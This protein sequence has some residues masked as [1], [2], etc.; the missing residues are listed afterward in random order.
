MPKPAPQPAMVD[1]ARLAG[2]S[3]QTVS[4]VLNDS[5]QVRPET[6]ARVRAAIDTLGYRPNR[7]ARALATQRSGLIGVLASG[8]PHLGPAATV[9]AIETATRAAG[10][11]AVVG[12]HS[13]PTPEEV[14]ESMHAFV[15]HG[16]QGIALVTP[17]RHTAETALAEAHGIPTVLIADLAGVDRPAHLVAVDQASGAG[18]AT[19][20]L[21]DGGARTIAH[22]AGPDGWFDADRRVE[23]WR[24]TLVA[25]G[26]EVPEV[27]YGDWS[28]ELGHQFG[29]EMVARG[30]PD[31]VFCA[32]DLTAIGLLAAFRTNG[33]R[34]P[35]DVTVVGFDDIPAAR[36]LS[37]P[38]STVRQ[39]FEQLGERAVAVLLE[40]IGGAA[41]SV[42]AL[43]PELVVRDTT[44]PRR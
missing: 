42:H 7:T 27:F 19:R 2:V 13:D 30:L 17:G 10:Y 31:A 4:R 39:P 18:Q 3:H 6:A 23:G 29:L 5:P 43:T 32:N 41:P 37:T 38:L 24:A 14:S 12:V 35:D 21:I 33:I 22:I 20:L 40:A 25:A 34:V 16:V 1:V 15:E 9:G 44:L 36:Y 8:F 26:L 11:S 28:P